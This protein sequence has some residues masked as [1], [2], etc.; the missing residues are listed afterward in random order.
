MVCSIEHVTEIFRVKPDISV[1]A[2]L[3][4]CLEMET[5]PTALWPRSGAGAGT[6]GPQP[7]CGWGSL[8][9]GNT[10]GFTIDLPQT[11]RPVTIFCMNPIQISNDG[12]KQVNIL[13][14]PMLI[15]VH[16]RDTG[17]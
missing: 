5:R 17:G 3:R 4:E 8:A 16:G 11:I 2:G 1:E 13:G 14:I 7:P 10:G 12:G 6:D 9:D 15:R